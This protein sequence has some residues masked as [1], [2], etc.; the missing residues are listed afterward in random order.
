MSFQEFIGSIGFHSELGFWGFVIF[1]MSI[2]I[3]IVPRIKWSP[4]TSLIRWLGSRFNFKVN[5]N[6]DSKMVG[7]NGKIDT[8]E[9]KVN[10]IETKVET[11]STNLDDHI[12]ESEINYLKDTR[13]DILNFCNACMNKRRHTREQF[14]FVLKQCDNYEKYIEDNKLKNGEI[15][16]AIKEIRRLHEK[17]LQENDFLNEGEEPEEINQKIIESAVKE[18]CSCMGNVCA[19]Y[20]E[21]EKWTNENVK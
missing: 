5:E 8:I 13:R 11:V 4:W 10:T 2:G 18:A 20:K 15:T 12:K 14:Q 9:K 3:E 21:K 17:C 16:A 6:I 7:L 19:N 1:L